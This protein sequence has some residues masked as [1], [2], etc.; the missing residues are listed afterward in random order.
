MKYRLGQGMFRPSFEPVAGRQTEVAGV[1]SKG[2]R[3]QRAV[4]VI[5]DPDG[6]TA[7]LPL[8]T[9]YWVNL[10]I[11]IVAEYNRACDA[12]V[13]Q[14]QPAPAPP[15]SLPDELAK[16]ARLRDE[17]VLSATEFEAQKRRLLG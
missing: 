5:T 1:T 3:G 4:V 14:L 17:G 13:A 8:T 11:Q 15:G 7:T 12:L 9:S 2:L 10:N 6:M 16:L